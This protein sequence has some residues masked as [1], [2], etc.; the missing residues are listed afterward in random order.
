MKLVVHSVKEF[1]NKGLQ[2]AQKT[3]IKW[4]KPAKSSQITG[5]VLDLTRSKA[6]LLAE[7]ALLRQQLL[8]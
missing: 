7:N 5:T 8:V 4:T 1:F 2:F 3:F 6:D